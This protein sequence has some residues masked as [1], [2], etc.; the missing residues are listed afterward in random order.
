V[1]PEEEQKKIRQAGI[2]FFPEIAAKSP[3]CKRGVE[4][5]LKYMKDEG[6]ID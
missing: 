3:G 2:E 1:W 6:L 5:F 4:I